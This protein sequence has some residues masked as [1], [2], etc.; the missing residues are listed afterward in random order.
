MITLGE[1]LLSLPPLTARHWFFTIQ[2]FEQISCSEKQSCPETFHCV[3]IVF[4]FQD[5][6]ATCGLPWKTEC[7]LNPL[8]LIYIHIFNHSEFL[9]LAHA[10]KNRVCPKILHCIEIFLSFKFYEELAFTLKTEFVMKF[11]AVFAKM[12]KTWTWEIC[13]PTVEKNRR[14]KQN[15][16]ETCNQGG[17]VLRSSWKNIR[18]TRWQF[19][20]KD[21]RFR[22]EYS[23][24]FI[25][26]ICAFLAIL[27]TCNFSFS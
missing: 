17:W 21:P 12:K 6:W 18:E 11:F 1:E 26:N 5:F 23:Q 25:H 7:A 20:W 9:K 3:E 13:F 19:S 22:G 14:S 16:A 8:F 27:I 4:I 10:L 2:I 15:S 24:L